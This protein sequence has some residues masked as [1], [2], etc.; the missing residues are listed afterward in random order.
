LLLERG[1][2]ASGRFSKRFIRAGMVAYICNSSNSGDR[3]REDQ[4]L[5]PA[6]G[7]NSR[8]YLKNN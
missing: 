6:P 8:P 3:D 1:T 4:D 2:E 5:R 7:K